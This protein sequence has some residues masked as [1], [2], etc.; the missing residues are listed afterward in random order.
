MSNE[1]VRWND[2]N[3]IAVVLLRFPNVVWSGAGH[4]GAGRKFIASILL[5]CEYAA[6]QGGVSRLLLNILY[7]IVV[8]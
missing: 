7:V 2:N 3:D 5:E 4:S 8:E 1:V 6:L